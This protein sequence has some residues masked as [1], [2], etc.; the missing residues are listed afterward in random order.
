MIVEGFDPTA[1]CDLTTWPE[2]KWEQA[3]HSYTWKLRNIYINLPEAVQ[4]YV[5]HSDDV[6]KV[7]FVREP[8]ERFWSAWA[9]KVLVREPPYRHLSLEASESSS[10][11]WLIRVRGTNSVVKE[12]R[13]FVDDFLEDGPATEEIHFFPQTELYGDFLDT[14]EFYDLR[15]LV[16]HQDRVNTFYGVELPHEFIRSNSSLPPINGLLS[17]SQRIALQ[18][19]YRSDYE[20][21]SHLFGEA[22]KISKSSWSTTEL[23]S[24][25]NNVRSTQRL[26]SVLKD[27][28]M[29]QIQNLS[30][31]TSIKNL[32]HNLWLQQQ[33]YYEV[34]SS[35][36]W[37]IT[38]FLRSRLSRRIRR[39]PV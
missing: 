5:I 1:V 13:R 3:V 14:A 10:T 23:E 8:L 24:V 4:D 20:Q 33:K 21:W 39:L 7:G 17:E 34:V 29:V 22:S 11:E 25:A 35:R 38:K 12:F 2:I 18:A 15:F 32:E 9:S 27:L 16:G 19:H 26:S 28:E 31:E 37:R 36:S 30:L 6:R